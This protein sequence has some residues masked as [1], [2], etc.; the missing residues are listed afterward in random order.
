MDACLSI[1]TVVAITGAQFC[2]RHHQKGNTVHGESGALFDT[3]K[4]ATV[5]E[6][7]T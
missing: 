4:R 2:S 1:G 5:N 7:G 6:A 3:A